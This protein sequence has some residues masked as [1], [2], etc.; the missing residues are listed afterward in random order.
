[1][2]ESTQNLSYINV[3]GNRISGNKYSE[4][5]DVLER[6]VVVER[7]EVGEPSSTNKTWFEERL[8]AIFWKRKKT[9]VQKISILILRRRENRVVNLIPRRVLI[10]M[11]SFL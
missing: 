8:N 11:F 7:L 6:C 3:V 4:L 10:S 9:N 1:M 2:I 5:L